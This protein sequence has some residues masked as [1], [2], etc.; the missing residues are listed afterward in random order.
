MTNTAIID[1]LKESGDLSLQFNGLNFERWV[2]LKSSDT[3][4]WSIPHHKL[5]SNFIKLP[6]KLS[7]QLRNLEESTSNNLYLESDLG[8]IL[9]V[10]ISD[11]VRK[12]SNGTIKQVSPVGK[13]GEVSETFSNLSSDDKSTIVSWYLNLSNVIEK[14]L[15]TVTFPMYGTLLGTIRNQRLIS[16]DNDLDLGFVVCGDLVNQYVDIQKLVRSLSLLGY[17][18]I[19]H[20]NG[21]VK[22]SQTVGARNYSADIFPVLISERGIRVWYEVHTRESFELIFPIKKNFLEGF[23]VSVPNSSEKLLE[24]IYGNDWRIPNPSFSYSGRREERSN[25][26]FRCFVPDELAISRSRIWDKFN[27]ETDSNAV[28]HLDCLKFHEGFSKVLFVG[29]PWD[30]IRMREFKEKIRKAEL[31]A[32]LDVSRVALS[33]FELVFDNTTALPKIE[34]HHNHLASVYSLFDF[35]SSLK[36]SE[37]GES[38][39][40][41]GNV[42]SYISKAEIRTVCWTLACVLPNDVKLLLRPEI[43]GE[44]NVNLP[45]KDSKRRDFFIKRICELGFKS[46][47]TTYGII[48]ERKP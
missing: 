3:I 21:I 18:C 34:T 11:Q 43:M 47:I 12:K 2:S 30:L 15:N 17:K 19:K 13:L 10:E 39:V 14:I 46:K 40:S 35:L 5:N 22:V 48:L 36:R 16:H 41:I 24:K 28:A 25:R 26:Y 20:S 31:L 37:E 38:L 1:E 42:I 33:E 44:I 9:K 29:C 4:L 8:M 27:S 6:S 32:C 23:Q 45:K 7:E